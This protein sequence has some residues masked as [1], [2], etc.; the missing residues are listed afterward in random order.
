MSQDNYCQIPFSHLFINTW[1]G[2]S[3]CCAHKID[4]DK[5]LNI[6]D[7][8]NWLQNWLTSDYLKSVQ[9]S[10]IENKRHVGC[11]DECW[12]PEDAGLSSLRT[13]TAN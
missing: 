12:V 2:I 5:Q 4:P 3:P 7:D 10:F 9:E 8:E 6:A 1:G 11:T 13:R